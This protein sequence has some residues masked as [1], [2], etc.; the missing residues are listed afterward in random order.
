MLSISVENKKTSVYEFP[1]LLLYYPV[2]V[3]I[4]KIIPI[5]RSSR[6]LDYF[7]FFVDQRSP[8]SISHHS[9]RLEYCGVEEPILSRIR[10]K[11]ISWLSLLLGFFYDA[12]SCF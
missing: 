6:Q 5:L 9:G 1:V 3:F 10:K 11:A 4:A 7:N 12:D 8:Q 2:H